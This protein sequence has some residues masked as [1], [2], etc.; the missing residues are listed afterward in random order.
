MKF[1]NSNSNN[2]DLIVFSN[3]H[4]NLDKEKGS[5]C[6]PISTSPNLLNGSANFSNRTNKLKKRLNKIRN[7]SINQITFTTNSA[8]RKFFAD[9]ISVVT[10]ASKDAKVV[11]EIRN[12]YE[13]SLNKIDT[14]NNLDNLTSID[15]SMN[16][17]NLNSS[18]ALVD[19]VEKNRAIFSMSRNEVIE[20]N[21]N[22]LD[23]KENEFKESQTK[24]IRCSFNNSRTETDI[25]DE[26]LNVTSIIR[27]L[28]ENE[29]K[30]SIKI[31]KEENEDK[32]F[33][34]HF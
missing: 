17:A 14:N 25:R 8:T 10:S 27:E 9:S 20:I 16:N 34:M 4:L 12:M 33:S 15:I 30:E 2:E 1:S 26:D 6:P 22:C 21:S 3:E 19:D 13:S 5:E 23:I 32:R 31:E 7:K 11:K 29:F 24:N 28:K 18:R